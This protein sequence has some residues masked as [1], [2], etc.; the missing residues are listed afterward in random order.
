M[1]LSWW[2][3]RCDPHNGGYIATP[4][5]HLLHTLQAKMAGNAACASREQTMDHSPQCQLYSADVHTSV[6]TAQRTLTAHTAPAAHTCA[7]DCANA[8]KLC[9]QKHALHC[10]Q[11]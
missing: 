2:H 8:C 11:L 9:M 4:A 6:S 3:T 10:R 5:Q 1:S 7:R